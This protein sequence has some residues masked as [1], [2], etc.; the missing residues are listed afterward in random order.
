MGDDLVGRLPQPTLV[1]LVDDG[2]RQH[3]PV[4]GVARILPQAEVVG[5]DAGDRAG[6]AD[7]R[8]DGGEVG[9]GAVEL[10]VDE[11][12]GRGLLGLRRRLRRQE[13][14]VDADGAVRR[15]ELPFLHPGALSLQLILRRPEMSENL[16]AV[17]RVSGLDE[18]IGKP[19]QGR[20]IHRWQRLGQFGQGFAPPILAPDFP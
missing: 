14:L 1:G 7:G 6:D 4:D 18:K 17:A 13:A 5:R 3:R 2:A 16:P 10:L 15:R 20:N 11:R 12:P 8:G 9:A 19:R